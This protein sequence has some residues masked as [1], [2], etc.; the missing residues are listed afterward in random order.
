MAGVFAKLVADFKTG[1]DEA[2]AERGFRQGNKPAPEATADEARAGG[3]GED[4]DNPSL[5]NRLTEKVKALKDERDEAIKLLADVTAAEK[6]LKQ[7]IEDLEGEVTRHKKQTN[8]LRAENTTKTRLIEKLTATVKALQARAVKIEDE[9]DTL[10]APL[11]IPGMK[12]IMLKVTHVDA[13]PGAGEDQ[14]RELNEW[15]QTVNAA[16]ALLKRLKQANAAPDSDG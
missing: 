13:H 16:F 14:R 3:D 12:R 9:R 4:A 6:P 10:A 8:K 7:R 5:V 2:Y 1:R 11:K 15:S